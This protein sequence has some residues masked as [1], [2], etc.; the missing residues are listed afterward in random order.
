MHSIARFFIRRPIACVMLAIAMVLAG[1]LAWRM[2]AV[3]P[4]PQVDFP[5]I[6]V[7]A[8]LP[9]AS[10]ESMAS[11]VAAPLERALG[12]IAGVTKIQSNSNQGSARVTLEFAF[13]RNINEA[14]REVQAAINASRS[15]LPAGM[16][17]NP[18]YTKV[19]PSQA[20]IMA[21][22]LSST[23]LPA[24]ALYDNASTILAQKIAQITGVGEVTVDGSSLPAVRVQLDA[25][26]LIH[27]GLS[28]EDVRRAING[29]NA[30][31]PLGQVET[32]SQRWQLALSSGMRTAEDFEQLIVHQNAGAVVRLR[33]VAVVSDSVENRYT[34]GYH[35]R[36]AAVI[37]L[38]SRRQDA[39]IVQ[40]IDAIHAAMPQLQAL[41]P[42]DT[43]LS[44]V[45]DRS[46]GIRATLSE[47][48]WTLVLTCL[49]VVAVV[50]AFLGSLRSAL[51]PAVALPISLIGAFIIMWWQGF[52][53]N[54]LS[55]MALIVAAGLVVDDAVVVLE[56]VQRH[57]HKY[58][59][60]LPH[61][62]PYSHANLPH[63]KS[64]SRFGVW[65][66]AL[67][68]AS[69]VG[70][71]LIAMNAALVVVFIAIL[72][73]GG[74][75]EKLFRE[76]SITLVAAIV[77]SLLV[78]ISLTPALCAHT[79]SPRNHASS[80]PFVLH[81]QAL[82]ADFKA[83]Y[84][85]TLAWVLRHSWLI[86]LL[87][88][89]LIAA[90][91]WLYTHLPKSM[92][93]TQDTG[94]LSGFVRGD[95]GFSFQ[96]MQPKVEAFRQHILADPA[97]ADVTGTSGGRG[98]ISNSWF[99]IRLKPLA[100]RRV[101]AA[102]VA[103]RLRAS[104]PSLPGAMLI[105]NVEQDIRL[106]TGQHGGE[107]EY[108]L[109]LR[110]DSTSTLRQWARPIG[111]ALEA[112]PE[113]VNVNVPGSEDAQQ[114]ELTID[115]E[116]AQR[117]G[118]GMNAIASALNN[119]FSQR[120]VATL[121]DNL[122][123]YKVVMELDPLFG[124]EPAAL[125]QVYIINT[126]GLRVPMS[127]FSTWRYGLSQDRVFHDS[128][129]AA[130]GIEY[131]LATGTTE[132]QAKAAIEQALTSL[133]LPAN[134]YTGERT[135][136][137]ISIEATVKRQPWL[138]LGVLIA[139][140]L[141]LGMLYESTL[142]PLT[143]LSTLPCASIGALLALQL[144]G[145]PFSLIALLGLFLL[146]GVVMKN[147]ILMIDFAL[148]AQRRL[149]LPAQTAIAQAA[150]QRLRPILMT[151]FAALL[152]A[153]PLV[154]GFGEGAELRRPQGIAIIGGLAISQLLTLYTTPVLYLYLE[155]LRQWWSPGASRKLAA[156]TSAPHSN[157]AP[158]MPSAPSS[159]SH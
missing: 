9:G 17:G 112:L 145:T 127:A 104:A 4:L 22:A 83:M 142:H 68:G 69:E 146:I 49:L 114:V 158:S 23:S 73:M 92:L 46:P 18:T 96:V 93:P 134:I 7:R 53:L 62:P 101:S 119:A 72:F 27:K 122:N 108:F 50:W 141:V 58:R 110:S 85:L 64:R 117:L 25:A 59:P 103:A 36:N 126:Q 51:I 11:T 115:R 91:A 42:A 155:R 82:F 47:A 123:Q 3:A 99:R 137:T 89:G 20:P 77:L 66:A 120:Q 111:D 12:A 55:L 121:Y 33:D 106:Q 125:E 129:F 86:V 19:N 147:A 48:Q 124:S 15:Q 131:G 52:S 118:V 81:G 130:L 63:N 13:D 24:A 95:D 152:G 67:R 74:V 61:T 80:H 90:N 105:V 32:G 84:A 34:A 144:S 70:P 6:E 30:W 10:P 35:N 150:Q 21:L 88:A 128:Q 71:T 132:L 37:L 56:N 78:S 156:Q 75:V 45:M 29:A 148:D 139:V 153:M 65:R 94:Q 38:I 140:Y 149:G 136:D 116:A 39:N 26:A 41:L 107:G 79:L 154:L 31:R 138:I 60:V 98:G 97:V 40:T 151:N 133:M 113:L 43:N 8:N 2:L 135:A 44:V 28:M 102:E 16:S 87:M 143:I 14:A 5:V 76:F 100:E 109:A 54:N 159:A 157:V 57:L 1:L